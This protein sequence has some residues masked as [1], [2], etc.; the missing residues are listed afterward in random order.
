LMSSL[1]ETIIHDDHVTELS[2]KQFTLATTYSLIE[3]VEEP[4]NG[5]TSKEATPLYFS[6]S[7][8]ILGTPAQTK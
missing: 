5:I 3:N 8:S 4:L 1:I 2:I 6:V 7:T